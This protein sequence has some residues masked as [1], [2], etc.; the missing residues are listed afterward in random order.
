MS[1]LNIL[2]SNLLTITPLAA[3]NTAR[4][5]QP[6][7]VAT[8][9]EGLLSFLS[10]CVLPLVP[11]YLSFI[12]GI[13]VAQLGDPS[14]SS[15]TSAV[16]PARVLVAADGGASLFE[17]N[18][19]AAASTVESNAPVKVANTRRVLI[20][21]LCFIAGLTTSFIVLFGLYSFLLDSIGDFKPAIQILAGILIIVFGLHFLGLFRFGIFN[22]ERRFHLHNKPVGLFGAY[23]LGAAF[24]FGWTPCV[25]PFLTAALNNASQSDT[26]GQGVAMMLVYSAGLGVPFLLAGLFFNRF[27]G[28][29]ARIKRH[30]R[31]IEIASGLLLIVVGLLLLTNNFSKLSELFAPL[32]PIR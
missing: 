19:M 4:S 5:V 25:G 24:A 16:A 21:T 26:A 1:I 2:D 14:P 6:E 18:E 8:F 23:L 28:F 29:M 20:S 10:P 9:F 11:G 22:M 15:A 17:E 30:F 3:L 13:S 12:S 31:V 27:L 32:T 7:V